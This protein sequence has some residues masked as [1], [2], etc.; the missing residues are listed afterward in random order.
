MLTILEGDTFCMSDAVG[1]ITEMHPRPLRE[2]HAHA[3]A[4]PPARRRR[5]AAPPDL[6]GGRVLHGGALRA[7]RAD[8]ASRRGHGLHL[9]R[10]LHRPRADGAHRPAQ[11]GHEHR[12]VPGRR[13]ARLRLRRHHLGQE[14]RLLLRRPGARRRPP[15]GAQADAGLARVAPDRGRRGL[16]DARSRSRRRPASRPTGPA[17]SSCSRPMPA[18]S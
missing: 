18:G 9:A 11:R 7:Q 10:A 4:A 15:A 5:A 13:R 16:H 17:T 14:L 6:E 3:L 1:D 8:R 12:R 2:R